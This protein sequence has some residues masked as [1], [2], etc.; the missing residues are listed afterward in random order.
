MFDIFRKGVVDGRVDVV[1]TAA[2]VLDNLVAGR[3]DV[4][5]VV[6]FA[7]AHDV[8]AR[9][10]VDDV[11]G[12]AA[13]NVV[14]AGQS[15]DVPG[16]SNTDKEHVVSVGRA[17]RRKTCECPQCSRCL[18]FFRHVSI[19]TRIET[20][21]KAAAVGFIADRGL[22]A[23][24]VRQTAGSGKG[25]VVEGERERDAKDALAPI[26]DANDGLCVVLD[27]V[28]EVMDDPAVGAEVDREVLLMAFA[29]GDQQIGAVAFICDLTRE[30]D[31]AVD[32]IEVFCAPVE[33]RY[34][35]IVI[36][37]KSGA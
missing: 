10:A 33:K 29:Q 35:I 17:R 20:I 14:I 6:A 28:E 22:A 12:V 27:D 13:G 31:V 2:G 26:L 5:G 11:A 3:V 16:A 9:A 15:V 21:D 36:E 30:I 37:L 25:V 1:K 23:G 4:I 7:A 8:V 18:K 19:G 32:L 34:G 24:I